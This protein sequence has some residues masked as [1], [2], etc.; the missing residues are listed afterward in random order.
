MY[1]FAMQLQTHTVLLALIVSLYFH[2]IVTIFLL[3][4]YAKK[5]PL[6]TTKII[7]YLS[8]VSYRHDRL[9]AIW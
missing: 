1:A 8:L 2:Y 4:M 6:V 7:T 5:V 3:I 9:L